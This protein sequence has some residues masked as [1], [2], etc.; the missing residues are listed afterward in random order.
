MAVIYLLSA[1]L[2]NMTF[3]IVKIYSIVSKNLYSDSW[4]NYLIRSAFSVTALKKLNR[5]EAARDNTI[6]IL[7]MNG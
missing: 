6:K 4:R 2:A 1:K 3:I 5:P 7:T